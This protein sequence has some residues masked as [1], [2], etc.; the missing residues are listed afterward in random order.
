MSAILSVFVAAPI[1]FVLNRIVHTVAGLSLVSYSSGKST[2]GGVV[3]ILVVWTSAA[4]GLWWVDMYGLI[5]G[6]W[7]DGGAV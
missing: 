6:W 7:T 1:V 3:L 4:F 2:P 5:R